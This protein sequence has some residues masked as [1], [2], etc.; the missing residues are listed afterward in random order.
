[1]SDLNAFEEDAEFVRDRLEAGFL[2]H[3]EVV[4][5]V[6]ETQFFQRFLKGGDLARLASTF[7][8]P[9]QKEE[10][11][12]WL[13]L[14]SQITLRLHGAPGFSSLPYILH[15]GGLRDS[16]EAGQLERKQDPET[17]QGY[18]E[19]K[20]YNQK[21]HESRSTPCDQD[22]VRKLAGDTDPL[23]LEQWYGTEVAK[24]FGDLDLYDSEGIFIVDGSYLFV[25]DNE[26]YEGSR[27]AVFDEHN[28]PISKEDEQKLT[29]AQKRRCR[30]RRY[31]QM[32]SLC[33]TNRRKDYLLYCGSHVFTEGGEGEHLVGLVERFV[34]AVG[35][36]VMKILLIDRGFIDGESF[37][38]IKMEFGVDVVVPLKKKMQ[39]TEDAWKLAEEVDTNPWVTWTPPPPEAPKD[40]ANRPEAVRRREKKR[41]A[42]L[43]KRKKGRETV[44]VKLLRVELKVIPKMQLW[45]ACPVPLDVVCMREHM[46]N[47]E[48]EKWGLMTTAEVADGLEI[49]DLY[50]LRP[51][52][53]EGWRQTKCYWDLTGFRSC[54]FSMVVS[55]V[56]FVEFAF[57]LLQAF[58]VMTDRGELAGTTRQRLL[59]ELLPDGEKVAAYC[60][61]RVA[62]LSV[63]EYSGILLNLTEGPRRRL[64]GIMRRLQKA[65]SEPPSLPRRPSVL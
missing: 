25:P 65:R 20:G 16:L 29:P 46:S 21:H 39:I 18:L 43:A 54:R 4:S 35:R 63:S 15:C 59:A 47:G 5:R 23:R 37:G 13:Y 48:V 1:M 2:D 19:F 53:E 51:T 7:P 44:G 40:P 36:G 11:P 45:K 49:R 26:H 52:V 27:V 56:T 64:Q 10:V 42:T 28:H 31:Y 55:H 17:G 57:S 58:L 3:V 34:Q 12:L 9:R 33:H 32:V 62:Y 61:N 38:R 22:F 60:E 8:T 14:S 30:W 41:Q 50:D 6:I 24:Y